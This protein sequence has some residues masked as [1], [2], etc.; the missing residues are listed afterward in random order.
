ME[1]G[2][3]VY[4]RHAGEPLEPEVRNAEWKKADPSA[5][6]GVAPESPGFAVDVSLVFGLCAPGNATRRF[7]FHAVHWVPPPPA[8]GAPPFADEDCRLLD[9]VDL[10]DPDLLPAV[11][12]T[13]RPWTG[14]CATSSP[15]TWPPACP[16]TGPCTTPSCGRGR[17]D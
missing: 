10:V 2:R 6:C 17:C 7:G 5:T 15:T 8:G 4:F 9:D 16:P 13:R 11:G 12:N 3:P 14:T 1:E